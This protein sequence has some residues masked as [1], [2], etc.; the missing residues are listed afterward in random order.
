[1]DQTDNATELPVSLSVHWSHHHALYSSH[2]APAQRELSSSRVAFV[3]LQ[4]DRF[5]SI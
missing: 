5:A 3:L 2:L 4:V 1:M